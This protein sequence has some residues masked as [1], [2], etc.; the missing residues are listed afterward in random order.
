MANVNMI[1]HEDKARVYERVFHVANLMK[2]FPY[3]PFDQ[4]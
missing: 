3:F 4:P 1:M 2:Y